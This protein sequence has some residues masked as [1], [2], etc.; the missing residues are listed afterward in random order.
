[1]PAHEAYVRLV[2]TAEPAQWNGLGHFFA[3]TSEAMRRM[4]AENARR[5]SRLELKCSRHC[6]EREAAISAE[7]F[8]PEILAPD[9]GPGRFEEK[10]SDEA[11]LARL[12]DFVGL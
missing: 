4:L 9:D 8:A 5:R 11:R 3:A 1:M 10:W 2:N 6:L 7:H 12:R